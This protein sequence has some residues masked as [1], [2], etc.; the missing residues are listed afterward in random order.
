MIGP[1]IHDLAAMEM[2]D[3]GMTGVVGVLAGGVR[4]TGGGTD[5]CGTRV[6]SEPRTPPFT[7]TPGSTGRPPPLHPSNGRT[8]VTTKAANRIWNLKSDV[9]TAWSCQRPDWQGHKARRMV[10]S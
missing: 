1:M 8:A 4:T 7:T 9:V 6:G 5:A 10:L 2:S 3:V